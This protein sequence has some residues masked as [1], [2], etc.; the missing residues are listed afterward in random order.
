MANQQR[1]RKRRESIVRVCDNLPVYKF[2]DKYY[3]ENEIK[4]TQIVVRKGHAKLVPLYKAIGL[5]CSTNIDEL[6]IAKFYSDKSNKIVYSTFEYIF[7]HLRDN[8]NFSKWLISAKVTETKILTD[9]LEEQD[10]S[11]QCHDIIVKFI[12]SLPILVFNNETLKRSDIIRP[13]K[14]PI[15]SNNR[16]VRYS[17]EEKL[18]ET[19]IIITNKL[20]GVVALLSK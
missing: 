15:I 8:E 13:Y 7:N 2:S 12:E 10:T 17:D 16:V 3:F 1:H 5:D 11:A 6:P 9:W 19:K 18:D 4:A 20:S 14:K